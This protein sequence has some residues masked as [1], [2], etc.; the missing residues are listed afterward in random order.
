MKAPRDS[1]SDNRFALLVNGEQ[2]FPA[3]F[4][5]IAAAR[6][7]VIV[8]TFILFD[9]AVGRELQ[10]VLI[11]AGARGVHVDVTVDGYGSPELSQT[12]LTPLVEAGVC[13]HLYDPRPRWFGKRTNI[14]R[15][16]HRKIVSIDA[17]IAFIGGINFSEDHLLCSG[18]D[19]KQDYAARIEG[20]LA[21][22]IHAFAAAQLSRGHRQA[23]WRRNLRRRHIR[24]VADHAAVF[25]W[26]DNE[27]HRD[28]IERHYRLAIRTARREIVIANA[29]FFPGYRLLH[30]LRRAARRGVTVKLI[31]QGK[32]DMEWVKFWAGLL[33]PP[34]L[35][36][37]V[38]IYEYMARPLHAKLAAIDGNWC[39]IGSS[40]LDPLSLA[41]NLEAN[42]VV[43]DPR[44]VDAV[45]QQLRD[46]LRE[47][48]RIDGA[49]APIHN[50]WRSFLSTLG[51]HATRY[52]P[53]MALWLPK[54]SPVVKSIARD[55]KGS[56]LELRELH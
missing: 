4:A 52:F 46:L 17:G 33:Y 36:S 43:R 14:F 31:L 40:N 11:A 3:V 49:Q 32:A 8:E 30:Q 35:R 48:R 42:I 9:D 34:L 27:V 51:Y 2:Y 24:A 22:E 56:A 38:Q 26:R 50:R 23:W 28:A 7:E 54:H 44:F 6:R 1:T 55:L 13:V 25:V 18:P 39:T 20:P 47:C 15:R 16:L 12:F 29:Y 5:A 37:G 10:S 21:A 19:A 53:V 45:E 41:L